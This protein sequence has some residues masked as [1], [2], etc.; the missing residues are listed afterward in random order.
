MGC[1]E[2][3]LPNRGA[4]R[5]RHCLRFC[6]ALLGSSV[7]Y[8]PLG[9]RWKNFIVKFFRYAAFSAKQALKLPSM[10][11]PKK[12]EFPQGEIPNRATT[13]RVCKQQSRVDTLLALLARVGG[14]RPAN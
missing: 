7:G 2:R 5:K 10:A 14:E 9:D 11:G 4:T 1:T 12:S 6:G 3:I 8:L 13:Q